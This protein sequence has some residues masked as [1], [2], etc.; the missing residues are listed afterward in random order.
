VANR[1]EQIYELSGS[2]EM[3]GEQLRQSSIR[4]QRSRISIPTYLGG[5]KRKLIV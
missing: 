4:K 5:R 3:I 2:N 1:L